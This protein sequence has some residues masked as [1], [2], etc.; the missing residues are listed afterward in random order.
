MARPKDVGRNNHLLKYVNKVAKLARSGDIWQI[1]QEALRIMKHGTAD[2]MEQYNTE[3]IQKAKR[4]RLEERECQPQ[5][6]C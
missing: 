4:Q 5:S 1:W 6:T 3:V 2:E